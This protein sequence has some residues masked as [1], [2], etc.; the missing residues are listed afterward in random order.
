MGCVENTRAR[1]ATY[2]ALKLPRRRFAASPT[3]KPP[4]STG[5]TCGYSNDGAPPWPWPFCPTRRSNNKK[6]EEKF[7]WAP[8]RGRAQFSFYFRRVRATE[9]KLGRFQITCL[10]P[11]PRPS[12]PPREGFPNKFSCLLKRKNVFNKNEKPFY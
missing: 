11:P 8:G 7:T 5:P 6:K 2:D 3:P 10:G 4:H 12:P 9:R 1:L